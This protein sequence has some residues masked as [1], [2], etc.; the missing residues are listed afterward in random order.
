MCTR[1]AINEILFREFCSIVTNQPA[2]AIKEENFSG[3]MLSSSDI[4]L[5]PVQHKE[6]PRDLSLAV[7]QTSGDSQPTDLSTQLPTDVTGSVETKHSP[8]EAQQQPQHHHYET[9]FLPTAVGQIKR[10]RGRPRKYTMGPFPSQVTGPSRSRLSLPSTFA[11]VTPNTFIS[12]ESGSH[13]ILEPPKKPRMGRPPK[14]AY[15]SSSNVAGSPTGINGIDNKVPTPNVTVS[16]A[17]SDE[18]HE[19]MPTKFRTP[20]ASSLFPKIVSYPSQT[21]LINGHTNAING[22]TSISSAVSLPLSSLPTSSPPL[23]ASAPVLMEYCN[24]PFIGGAISGS[25]ASV[26]S[27]PLPSAYSGLEAGLIGRLLPQA[28]AAVC[29]TKAAGL[30]GP[31][32]WTPEMVGSFISTLPGCQN[33][34]ATFIDSEIDGPALLCLEQHDLMSILK[35]KLGPAVKVFGAIRALRQALLSIPIHD[36]SA[37]HASALA[38]VVSCFSSL[39]SVSATQTPSSTSGGTFSVNKLSVDG[40]GPGSPSK[41]TSSGVF[42]NGV[43]KTNSPPGVDKSSQ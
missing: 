23:R 31:H 33:L 1:T 30:S 39:N 19:I 29:A 35:L 12:S 26:V 6:E 11:T 5:I 17:A 28:E 16:I 27:S 32:V 40:E 24:N 18:H 8:S 38:A 2:L 36:L 4:G 43:F 37:D 21:S 25:T 7:Q 42:L 3:D 41:Q 13:T 15:L 34:A 10:K 20:S 9:K 22:A 14:S